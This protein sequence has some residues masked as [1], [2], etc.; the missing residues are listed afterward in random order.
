M[1]RALL[2]VAALVL[3]L[4][5][6]AMAVQ[7]K[8][9][10]PLLDWA[11]KAP[12]GT[13]RV[14]VL[15]EFGLKD[16]DGR[17]WSG[18]AR[19]AGAK[20]VHREGYRFRE[21]DKLTD[22]NGWEASSHRGLRAPKGKPQVT[23]LERIATV[24]VVLHLQDVQPGAKLRIET[25]KGEP[26]ADVAL[27]EVRA[28]KAHELWNGQAVARLVT[29]AAPAVTAK[30]EDDFPAAAYAPDGTLWMASISYTLRDPSRRIEAA[31][32][33]GRPKDFAGLYH[34][35]YADQLFLRSYR[36]GKWGEPIAVTGGQEDLARCAVA[37]SGQGDVW[38]SYSAHR[39]GKFAIYG[40]KGDARGQLG[41]EQRLTTG[42]GPELTPVM[43]TDARG[44]VWLA[45]QGWDE[46]GLAGIQTMECDGGKWEPRF[47]VRG[48]EGENCW[49][50]ALAA[51]GDGRVALAYDAYRNG[52]YDVRA[53]LVEPAKAPLQTRQVTVA[54][55][56]R[57][58]AR[59]SIVFDKAGRLWVAFEDGPEKWGK[60]YGSLVPDRGEPLYGARSVRVVCVDRGGKR[61]RPVAQL[62]VSTVEAPRLAGD[63]LRTAQ[64][65]RGS[66]WAFPKI[67]LDGQGQVW[68][69]YRR[70]FGTRYTTNVGAYWLTFARR[71]D[72]E[73]WGEE[74]E[75]HHSDGLLD[76]RPVVLP[77]AGGGLLIVHNTDGR[78]TTP[79]E[80]DNQIYASVVALA[81]TAAAPKLVADDAREVDGPSP[82]YVAERQA[83]ERM[84]SHR[85]TA[86]GKTYQLRRGEFHRHTEISWDG[87]PDGALEDM[88][89]Y[90]IDAVGFDWIGN[91]DH[92][93]G[94]GRE[95][96]WWLIQKFSDAYHVAGRFTPMFTY[97]RS[98]SYPHGHRNV[99]FARRGV[100]TLPRLAADGAEPVAGVHPDDTK[101][102][103]RYLREHGGL[104]ASHTSATGMGT[105]WRDNDPVA[106]PIVEIY[107]GD[108]MSYEYE[109]APRSG[110]DP[111]SGKE[112]ANI[113]G[114]YPKGFINHALQKGYRLG[115][116]S[117]SDHWSTHISFFV[118]LAEQPTRQGLLDAVR[119]RHCYGATD[120]IVVDFR[121][122]ERIMG[123]ELLAAKAPTFCLHVI[124][125]GDLAKVE[126]LR[127][128]EVV[129]S[130]PVKGPQF[131]GDWTDPQPP[132]VGTHYYYARVLQENQELA[133]ASP[134]WVTMK[135]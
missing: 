128:S 19:V 114:W 117:S 10:F 45:Y 39:D 40:R 118:V 65:E 106:E 46:H 99:M 89:R 126:M 73:R 17:D 42:A 110:F 43:C 120:N 61:Q 5:V 97:E 32:L 2:L 94:A 57:F 59:P 55:S 81:G 11:A 36:D 52:S 72:G 130:L 124:G 88:F 20:V 104:C 62:P 60:D 66:R 8:H 54:G 98:V 4:G 12:A 132:Q 134:I 135:E 38:V 86:A 92:D 53:V 28:G 91:G 75:V 1:K 27:D 23:K 68:L 102:L 103:Y 125:T 121:A 83:I 101:M 116:Q 131:K 112:P 119:R 129:A 111:K 78:H 115:F 79:A 44:N 41:P 108:R 122:G 9:A 85:I 15:L 63:P 47:G 133:W 7:E 3:V 87:S 64:F 69:T 93:N 80:I 26:A 25:K 127:D 109:G 18:S 71:L 29:A 14:A 51:A 67:G 37:V 50:P 24:G 35:G 21:G 16:N 90:A 96:P 77:H 58:E 13:P 105:D 49:Y 6:S 34:P 31:A 74:I 70:N 30:T 33:K 56:P 22:P 107:Q 123:D 95:Y 84:R 48:R 82:E 76:S 113:A 100:L